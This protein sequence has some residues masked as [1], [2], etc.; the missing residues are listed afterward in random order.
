M[1]KKAASKR[2]TKKPADRSAT[3]SARARSS[4]GA[5]KRK[6]PREID[7]AAMMAAWQ[8]A[9]TPSEGHKRLEPMVGSWATKT[10]FTMCPGEPAD[11]STGRSE[12]RWVLG[13]RYLE[14]R[15]TG[16]SMGMPFEGLGFTGYDNI[17]RKY[18]GT[19]MDSFGT[20]FMNSVGV[21]RAKG[22]SL[23]FDAE[24]VDPSGQTV[25]FRC[26][27]QIQDRNRHNYEMWT[28]APNGKLYRMMRVEYSRT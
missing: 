5:A 1:A 16:T 6:A 25:R 9:M 17:Q 3:K 4:R 15:Y 2:A 23:Q 19:W 26:K 21:G 7:Q 18:V 13:G 11:V 22:D 28:H 24:A 14:Q 8:K 12:H 27:L 20:G 10:T